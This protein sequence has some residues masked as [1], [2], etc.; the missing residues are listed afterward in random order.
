VFGV[1]VVWQFFA[2][3]SEHFQ[4]VEPCRTV[5]FDVARRHDQRCA[6]ILVGGIGFSKNFQSRSAVVTPTRSSTPSQPVLLK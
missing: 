5:A 1:E 3:V 2:V 6:V 4:I